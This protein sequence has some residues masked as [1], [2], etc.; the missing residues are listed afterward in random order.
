MTEISPDA[1]FQI[2]GEQAVQLW[3]AQRRIAQLE[4]EG[5]AKI[6]EFAQQI[7]EIVDRAE[8]PCPI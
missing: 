8:V 4:G 3:I 5:Q 2:I 1:L 7:A 6:S